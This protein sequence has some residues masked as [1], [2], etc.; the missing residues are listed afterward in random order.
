M[1]LEPVRTDDGNLVLPNTRLL[2]PASQYRRTP[3]E[4]SLS[5]MLRCPDDAEG[6]CTAVRT[7]RGSEFLPRAWPVFRPQPETEPVQIEINHRRSV[8]SQNLTDNQAPNDRY[9]EGPSK[10]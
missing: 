5:R 3:V 8:K 6:P 7:S 10:L 4:I 1:L 2:K 9:A